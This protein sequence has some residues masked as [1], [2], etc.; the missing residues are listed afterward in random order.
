MTLI[1][2]IY[3]LQNP[4]GSFYIGFTETVEVRITQHNAG[5]SRSTRSKGPWTLIW[6]R[7]ALTLNDARRLE[8]DL[9]H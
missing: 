4:R 6:Q 1:Y 5:M 3:V 9:K 8:L 2:R 7:E